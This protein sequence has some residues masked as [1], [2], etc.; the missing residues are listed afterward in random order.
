MTANGNGKISVDPPRDWDDVAPSIH[1]RYGYLSHD[2][3]VLGEIIRRTGARSVL[4]IGGGSGRLVPVYLLHSMRPIWVQDIS[5]AALDIC[6]Q[7]F[8]HQEQIR[9]FAGYVEE[10][11]MTKSVDLV[12][13]TRVLQYILDEDELR[14]TIGFL[15]KKTRSFFI[16]E[17]MVED[18]FLLDSYSKGRDYT[19]IFQ[20]L[21][22]QLRD[23]GELEAERGAR[24]SWK[25][26]EK[27]LENLS[28]AAHQNLN[29]P[30]LFEQKLVV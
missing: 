17:A 30:D 19:A 28:T 29:N 22:F 21:G 4:E 18:T 16:N 27:D 20:S 24:Q 9:Y 13:S 11:V 1:S 2:Y 25:L 14:L 26:F 23:Q 6:R 10:M 12:I 3:I 15:A 8:F 5:A 7:R